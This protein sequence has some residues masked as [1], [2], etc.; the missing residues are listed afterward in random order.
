ML[1]EDVHSLDADTIPYELEVEIVQDCSN[2][3]YEIAD[4][5]DVIKSDCDDYAGVLRKVHSVYC[6]LS[7]LSSCFGIYLLF[8]FTAHARVFLARHGYG[9]DVLAELNNIL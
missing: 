5:F 4:V 7:F 1:P 8:Q 6:M 9:K 2:F 3:T